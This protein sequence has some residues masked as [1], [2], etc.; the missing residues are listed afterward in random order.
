MGI[1]P[2]P[3]KLPV[4]KASISSL[5]LK[6]NSTCNEN[7]ESVLPTWVWRTKLLGIAQISLHMISTLAQELHWQ[8]ERSVMWL[9][10]RTLHKATE[11][12]YNIYCYSNYNWRKLHNWKFTYHTTLFLLSIFTLFLFYNKI[13][14]TKSF[15]FIP[16]V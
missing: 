10:L 12:K 6:R 3:S 14:F 1:S 13:Y 2:S 7:E 5:R 9:T 16:S 8:R 11:S 15:T 4:S